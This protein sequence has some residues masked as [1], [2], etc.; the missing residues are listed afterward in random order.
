MWHVYLASTVH[1]SLSALS[2]LNFVKSLLTDLTLTLTALLHSDYCIDQIISRYRG[3]SGSV[4]LSLVDILEGFIAAFTL[5][6][7]LV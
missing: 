1:S 4:M 7:H 6:L 3:L 5:Q 2:V